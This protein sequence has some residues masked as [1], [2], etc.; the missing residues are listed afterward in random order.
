MFRRIVVATDGSATAQ[1]GLRAALELAVD[2]RATVYA[3]YVVDTRSV[4]PELDAAY[5][6]SAYFDEYVGAQVEHGRNVLS[7]AEAIAQ[8]RGVTCRRVL[9]EAKSRSVADAILE[10]A[11]RSR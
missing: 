9:A 6:P 1:R 3:V 7:Q 4:V 10:Q 8:S 11:R 5:V 2:Q